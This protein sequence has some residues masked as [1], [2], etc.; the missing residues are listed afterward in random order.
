MFGVKDGWLVDELRRRDETR[1]ALRPRLTADQNEKALA[2]HATLG[3]PFEERRSACAALKLVHTPS[4]AR[5]ACPELDERPSPL[6]PA[7]RE[8]EEE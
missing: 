1:D 5:E 2:L 6:S 8:G 7:G 4:I 3:F